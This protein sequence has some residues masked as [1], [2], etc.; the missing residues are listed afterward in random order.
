MKTEAKLQQFILKMK[1]LQK[2]LDNL[3]ITLNLIHR[4]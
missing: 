2:C 4:I 3:L 1:I